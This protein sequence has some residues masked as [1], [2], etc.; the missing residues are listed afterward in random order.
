MAAKDYSFQSGAFGTIYLAKNNKSKTLMSSDRR[1]ITE[2]ELLGLFEHYVL[3]KCEKDKCKTFG[4]TNGYGEE[5]FEVKLSQNEVDK[6]ITKISK[7]TK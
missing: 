2:N 6:I 1:A 3:N 4:V 7:T 5:I